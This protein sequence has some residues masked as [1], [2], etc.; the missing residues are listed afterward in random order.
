MSAP[1]NEV[2]RLRGVSF[3]YAAEPVIQDIDLTVTAHEFLG[4]V[5]PNAGGKSTLL[6]LILG[7][8]APQAGQ[9]E[10]L[11]KS[12]RNAR[13]AIGYVPQYPLFPRN[14]PISV[15]QVVM[16]GRLGTGLGFGGWRRSDR[17]ATRRTL[18]EVEAEGLAKRQIGT[19]SG[20]QLQRILL[21]RALVSEPHILILDE[22]TASVDLRLESDIFE[23]LRALTERLTILLVSHD[24]AF[25]SRYITRVAC[26]NRTL[27]CHHTDSI[28]GAVIQNLYGEP[29]RRVAHEHRVRP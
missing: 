7:L 27:V 21:A 23:L 26:I 24:V 20:G 29:V 25:I 2:I 14:F 10:V 4:I 5:G 15:E 6:K 13:R 18:Q 16:M 8:L 9:I 12:P 1:S 28:D 11:G 3:A 17:Q 19:L 22:P